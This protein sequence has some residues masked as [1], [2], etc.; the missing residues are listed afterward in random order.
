MEEVKYIP[1]DLV[2]IQPSANWFCIGDPLLIVKECNNKEFVKV[3]LSKYKPGDI[4]FKSEY[5]VYVSDIIP[6]PLTPEI[7]EKNGWE[8]SDILVD[9]D[10]SEHHL[11]EN[12]KNLVNIM[13]V[14]ES[15]R[16][17]PFIVNQHILTSFKYVH[18]FQHLLFGLGLPMDLKV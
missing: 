1:G 11:Y 16:F 7:L 17:L 9:E 18:Q 15:K 3:N 13:H 6:I 10:G 4:E 5:R 8:K 12:K 14:P 2:K